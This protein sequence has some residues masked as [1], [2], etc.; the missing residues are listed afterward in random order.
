MLARRID[1]LLDQ[2]R[3]L[4]YQELY[5]PFKNHVS[6]EPTE[7]KIKSLQ[8]IF[9]YINDIKTINLNGP[10]A[11]NT[12]IHSYERMR[13]TL[14]A[15]SPGLVRTFEQKQENSGLVSAI[16]TSLL[17]TTILSLQHVT[18]P[19][20]SVSP[21]AYKTKPQISLDVSALQK[22]FTFD[23]T[24]CGEVSPS[25]VEIDINAEAQGLLFNY[26]SQIKKALENK[27]IDLSGKYV[28][29]A[30]IGRQMHLALQRNFDDK[31]KDKKK[32][33][34]KKH[35]EI[36]KEDEISINNYIF[37]LSFDEFVKCLF[38]S[39]GSTTDFNQWTD[40]EYHILSLIPRFMSDCE[41]LTTTTNRPTHLSIIKS[42]K[43][44]QF[45]LI[46]LNVPHFQENHP[47]ALK[48]AMTN[49]KA[50][51]FMQGCS[52]Q[53]AFNFE[54]YY[55][56][57]SKKLSILSWL[58]WRY[59]E[60]FVFYISSNE[61]NN[62]NSF[63]CKQFVLCLKKYISDHYH[64]FKNLKAVI[65]E[66]A[67]EAKNAMLDYLP[68]HARDE[69]TDEQILLPFISTKQLLTPTIR[70]AHDV[71]HACENAKKED[72]SDCKVVVGLKSHACLRPGYHVHQEDALSTIKQN[73]L[74]YC[75][76]ILS[77]LTNTLGKF[78]PRQHGTDE[79]QYEAANSAAG[80]WQDAYRY[81]GTQLGL[82][83]LYSQNGFGKSISHMGLTSS[84]LYSLA[85]SLINS[86]D[87]EFNENK[88]ARVCAIYE[89]MKKSP[90]PAEKKLAQQL[91]TYFT[92]NQIDK[93]KLNYPL[94]FLAQAGLLELE[95]VKTSNTEEKD[96]IITYFNDILDNKHTDGT[97][98]SLYNTLDSIRQ[99]L[100]DKAWC[101]FFGK[102][103]L[104]HFAD[105]MCD[106]LVEYNL[107]H[108]NKSHFCFPF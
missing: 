60:G 78:W 48:E 91:S 55:E 22:I 99:V 31:F 66:D 85:A 94:I 30:I 88:K 18:V 82:I 102:H 1:G 41:L 105:N 28:P 25:S 92:S 69:K 19:N 26:I 23:A 24:F 38:A 97:P 103:R 13:K 101:N 104:R 63:L 10:A 62:Q 36:K 83:R 12:A 54:I 53:H 46:F 51:E 39:T 74:T 76:N 45:D 73:A 81:S 14:F 61:F 75:T 100:R 50:F 43:K 64:L 90:H 11:I 52:L 93:Y 68:T 89:A 71:L 96:K 59:P 56:M 3:N 47:V 34:S 33:N 84:P 35:D 108:K 106:Q 5:I 32:S 20:V 87:F 98:K 8:T 107:V 44:P 86:V 58:N 57:L 49:F 70:F 7:E 4:I 9:N 42:K 67:Q 6:R 21:P 2:F 65:C 77:R 95:H 27:E 15:L 16:K 37:S 80:S 72:F 17:H 40:D 29:N 79:V